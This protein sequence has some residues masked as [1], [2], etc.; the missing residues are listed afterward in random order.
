M[1]GNPGRTRPGTIRELCQV[2]EEH[3]LII[4]SDEI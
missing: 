2:A 4:V 3:D 1:A